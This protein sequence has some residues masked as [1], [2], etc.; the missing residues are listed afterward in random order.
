MRPPLRRFLTIVAGATG[1]ACLLGI[2]LDL[3]TANVAV[4]YFSVHHPRIVATNN[5]WV[6][7]VVW[8][9]AASWWFGAISGAIVAWVNHRRPS[10]LE[11]PQILRWVRNACVTLWVVM[12]GILLAVLTF[13]GTIPLEKRGADF[14]LGARLMAVALAHLSE[15]ALG[16]IALVVIAV[17]TWRHGRRP[18]GE[19]GALPQS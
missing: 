17:L 15:Y 5:P 19:S 14:A 7:A 12:I 8:G 6:L 13:A 9:I 2:C 1:L 11:P 3:V 18:A 10:P 4:E 16:A